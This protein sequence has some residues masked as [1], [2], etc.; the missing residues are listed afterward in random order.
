MDQR[1]Y[2]RRLISLLR[3]VRLFSCVQDLVS[4]L[5]DGVTVA[6]P[7]IPLIWGALHD[8]RQEK[9]QEKSDSFPSFPYQLSLW[10]PAKSARLPSRYQINI[11]SM[12]P[13]S[14]PASSASWSSLLWLQIETFFHEFIHLYNYAMRRVM[15]PEEEFHQRIYYKDEERVKL[16]GFV[17][18][19]N[20]PRLLRELI[21]ELS[22]RPTCGFKY[23]F[24]TTPFFYYHRSIVGQWLRGNLRYH[25][26]DTRNFLLQRL[27]ETAQLLNIPAPP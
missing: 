13:E 22:A 16:S 1:S 26:F 15:V 21:L 2:E 8:L 4:I 10:P 27:L 12:W 20:N 9:K 24:A 6:F 14:L 5:D 23:T 18:A 19:R 7:D 25:G 3:P 17:M 11:L